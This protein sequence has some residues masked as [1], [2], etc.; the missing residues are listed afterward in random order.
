MRGGSATWDVSISLTDGAQLAWHGEPFVVAAGADVTRSM[1]VSLQAG[2]W[3]SIRESLVFGRHGEVGGALRSSQR[4]WRDGELLLAEDLDLSPE[5][6]PGWAILGAARCLDSVTTLGRRIGSAAE[7]GAVLQLEGVGSVVRRLV[8]QQHE[9]DLG[10]TWAA[11]AT[12]DK[13][14]GWS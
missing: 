8:G 12:A 11:L 5:S 9:S 7:V 1:E 10:Q 14:S 4:A 6:R 2:C 13:I 3:A